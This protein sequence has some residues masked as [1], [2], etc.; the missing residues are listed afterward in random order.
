[1]G[2]SPQTSGKAGGG[3]VTADVHDGADTWKEIL[4]FRKLILQSLF[5]L[6]RKDALKPA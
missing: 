2:F 4:T 6:L 1:M 3:L 5:P